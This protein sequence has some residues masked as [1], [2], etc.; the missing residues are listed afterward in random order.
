MIFTERNEELLPKSSVSRKGGRPKGSKGSKRAKT[1]TA[2]VT[3]IQDAIFNV[4]DLITVPET[5][6]LCKKQ[7]LLFRRDQI[8]RWI[9]KYKIGVKIGGRYFVNPQAFALL[10][11][12][13]IGE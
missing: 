3:P 9:K 1:S 4:E 8:I 13:Q 10:L 12:G 2:D 6:L 11:K 7:G 5:L